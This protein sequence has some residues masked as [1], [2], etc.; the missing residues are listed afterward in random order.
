M[1]VLRLTTKYDPV[2]LVLVTAIALLMIGGSFV[3]MWSAHSYHAEK[4]ERQATMQCHN[5]YRTEVPCP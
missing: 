4:I 1:N 3:L 2:E 5:L